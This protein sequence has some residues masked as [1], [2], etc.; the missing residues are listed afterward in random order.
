ME[1]IEYQAGFDYEKNDMGVNLEVR[2][3]YHDGV[4][5]KYIASF[6]KE[7]RSPPLYRW[8]ICPGYRNCG[9]VD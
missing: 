4:Y 8:I 5:S 7:I 6:Y 2:Q 9:V 1:D 3:N